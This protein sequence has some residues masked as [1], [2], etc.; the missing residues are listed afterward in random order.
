MAMK[1]CPI[2][3]ERYSDT[4]KY[5]PF[6]EEEEEYVPEEEPRRAAPRRGMR[7]GGA[8][9]PNLIT[10]VLIVLIVFMAALL[11]YLLWGDK[12]AAR[13]KKDDGP[14][15]PGVQEPA[16]PDGSGSSAVTPPETEAPAGP[17]SSAANP[18]TSAPGTGEPG[19]SD[20]VMPENPGSSA[21]TPP[22]APAA[23]SYEAV[24][25]L[26]GGLTLN[27]TD[28]TRSVSE[29]AYQ[30][31]ASGGSGTYTWVSQDPGIASVDSTGRVTPISSGTT[32][33]LATD[34]SRKAVCIVRVRGGSAP[35]AS[36]GT[37]SAPAD[38]GS[39][40]GN[41]LNRED[42]TLSVGEQFKL[43]LS[44][45]TTGLSWS[46]ADTGIATVAG[47]GTVTGVSKGTTRVTVS[48]DGQ[49]RTCIVR[50]K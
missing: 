18:G 35:A 49:S 38:T 13:F 41:T 15:K 34:G 36:G 45:V 19:G 29:G 37:T 43:K 10:P 17:D 48:W 1:R 28:F 7:T 50:V 44:G 46:C 2:C 40:G 4:Y 5:C 24:N 47:D 12:I 6:C 11:I 25:A 9:Q 20:P 23:G 27:K 3:G 32:N 33:I 22:V 21:T 31:R 39:S 42:M 30:L 14:D 8:R 26:P 16:V